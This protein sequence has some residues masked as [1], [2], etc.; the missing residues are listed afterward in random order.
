[1][2][3]FLKWAISVNAFLSSKTKQFHPFFILFLFLLKEEVKEAQLSDSALQRPEPGE[4]GNSVSWSGKK[5]LVGWCR[6]HAS[7]TW[8]KHDTCLFYLQFRFSDVKGLHHS[9]SCVALIFVTLFTVQMLV[10]KKWVEITFLHINR[11]WASFNH[12]V[13]NHLKSVFLFQFIWALQSHI[14]SM[15]IHV[16]RFFIS[17]P[18]ILRWLCHTVQPS[19]LLCCSCPSLSLDTWR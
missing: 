15:Y 6:Q 7:K 16:S 17:I 8:N 14:H 11:C 4:T 19:L 18:V 1:M 5:N 12:Y 10:S 3:T 2:M 13:R 9:L